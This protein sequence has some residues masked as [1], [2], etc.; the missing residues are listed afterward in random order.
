MHQNNFGITKL[1]A[2][3]VRA[4]REAFLAA[5]ELDAK[6]PGPYY[7]LAILEQF[8]TFD[9]P[10]ARRWFDAYW[11]RAKDDPDSLVRALGAHR[12][13]ESDDLAKQGGAR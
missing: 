10:A 9:E 2:G 8:Y 5:I 13:N 4:A 3:D 12:A 7:N 6:L 11:Q 1:R